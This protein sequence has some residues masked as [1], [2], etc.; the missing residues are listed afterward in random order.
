MKQQI[1]SNSIKSLED[2]QTIKE[3]LRSKHSF[4][5]DRHLLYFI[6]GIN[7]CLKPEQLLKLKWEQILNIN[8][9]IRDFIVY[10]GYRFYLN[11]SCKDAIYNF[12]S[13]YDNYKYYQYIFGGNKSLVIQTINKVLGVAEKNL[14][15][16]Y[17]LSA[18]SLHKT[19]IYW[20][21]VNYHYDYTKMSKLRYLIYQTSKSKDLNTYAEYNINDDMIYINDI[22]L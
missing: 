20:Q 21:V 6:L 3:Y 7:I 18:L 2:I 19:F 22:N 5:Y 13:Q 16:Q 14:H 4:N 12:M 1:K 9:T 11:K 10:N 15:L 8:Y 17:N